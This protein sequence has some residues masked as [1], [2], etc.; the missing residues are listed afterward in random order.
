MSESSD[1][2]QLARPQAAGQQDECLLPQQ[3][4]LAGAPAAER[5]FRPRLAACLRDGLA[6]GA[7]M[8][9][10]LLA[11]MVPVSLAVTLLNFTGLLSWL[12]GGFEGVF[13]LLGLPAETVVAFLTAVFLNIYSGIAALGSIPLTDRQVTILALM[14]LIAHNFPVEATI[15][16]KV[17]SSAVAMMLLRLAAAAGGA[18][19]LNWLMP[20]AVGP[21]RTRGLASASKEFWPLLGDWAVGTAVLAGKVIGIVV[22]LMIL[23]RALREFGLIRLLAR[24]LSPLLWVAGLP[25]RVAFLWIVANT[26]GLAYGAAVIL[27]E[28]RGQ[29]LDRRDARLLNPSMAICHSL[30]EDT[31]L[32]VAIGAWA[33]WI[34]LPRVALAA[35]VVWVLRAYWA[36]KGTAGRASAARP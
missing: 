28:A 1:P 29:G 15:Q 8:A 9:A 16:R 10:W 13:S 22:G 31:L 24:A 23:Q 33:A 7:R 6:A 12:A 5:A 34:T 4:S 35:G 25:R 2:P 21:A 3:A 36:M 27:E 26:L 17:G 32:F 19:L 18:M 11:I 20:A 30:L 14:M